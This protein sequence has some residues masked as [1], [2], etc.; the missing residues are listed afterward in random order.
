MWNTPGVESNNRKP[1]NWVE[2][3]SRVLS[4]LCG[5]MRTQWAEQLY[6]ILSSILFE[7]LN[8]IDDKD[9]SKQVFFTNIEDD[10]KSFFDGC[11]D[12]FTN[13]PE[14]FDNAFQANGE[15]LVAVYR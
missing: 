11:L 5:R 8:M 13:M 10:R 9:H 12:V 15:N 2:R 6:L 1:R 3:Q 4:V 14:P 7:F